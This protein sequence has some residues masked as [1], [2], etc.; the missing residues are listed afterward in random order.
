MRKG[1][2]GLR[3][4]VALSVAA[5]VSGCG[6]VPVT[7]EKGTGSGS[8][9][10]RGPGGIGALGTA[11]ADAAGG[12]A[13]GRGVGEGSTAAGSAAATVS[14]VGATRFVSDGSS[15]RFQ[16]PSKNIGCVLSA[17]GVRCDIATHVWVTPIRP[18]SCTL[19]YG[20]GVHLED[21]RAGYVCAGN[22]L[23]QGSFDLQLAYGASARAGHILCA[24]TRI[25]VTCRNLA[26]G[27]GFT[28]SRE[29]FA[30]F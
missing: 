19:D 2:R 27:H 14:G 4:T 28:L 29:A 20:R 11:V 9:R 3:W 16:T 12:T 24:S 6:G 21:G 10:A 7:D 25:G 23:L 30:P 13:P 17:A 26:T 5:L 22:S 18:S 1:L 15:L 8:A